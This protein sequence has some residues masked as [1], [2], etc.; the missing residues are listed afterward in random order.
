MRIKADKSAMCTINRH[1]LYPPG[2]S[3]CSTKGV[4][5]PLLCRSCKS[6]KLAAMKL[7]RCLTGGALH[8]ECQG[9]LPIN[10]PMQRIYSLGRGFERY[11]ATQGSISL[12]LH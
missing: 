8:R 2:M 9:A 3:E 12:A 6:R 10:G 11:R 1:L 7:E 5:L 4:S